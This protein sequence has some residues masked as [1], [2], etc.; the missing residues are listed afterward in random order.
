MNHAEW[1]ELNPIRKFRI[2]KG[3]KTVVGAALEWRISAPNLTQWEA[4]ICGP[5]GEN[6]LKMEKVIPGFWNLFH[7][8]MKQKPV[9]DIK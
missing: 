8:W 4:G 6:T 2:E 7:E 5:N 1:I 9:E 3:L